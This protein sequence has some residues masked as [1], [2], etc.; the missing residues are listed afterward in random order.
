MNVGQLVSKKIVTLSASS[1]VREAAKTMR[2]N[3]VSSVLLVG[4]K[5]EIR[6]IV[7][8]RDVTRAVAEGLDYSIPAVKIGMSP[9]ISVDRNLSV[10]EALEIMG[11]KRIRHVLVKDG[12]KPIGVVSLREMAN[13]LSLLAFAETSY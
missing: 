9:V 3:D 13:A 11:E 8:E 10:L 12:D 4:E 5:G 6:A 2:E 1:S 7:T